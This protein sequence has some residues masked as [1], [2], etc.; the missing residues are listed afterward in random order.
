MS[1]CPHPEPVAGHCTSELEVPRLIPRF[2]SLA[3][4]Y[5]AD[6]VETQ[7][8][9]FAQIEEGLFATFPERR[10]ESPLFFST[11]GR[12]ELCG[13]HTDHNGGMV[14]AASVNLDMVAAA[15]PSAGSLVRIHSEGFGGFELDIGEL[16]PKPDE[17]AS[18][19]ALVR[20]MAEGLSK[21][22]CR[23]SAALSGFDAYIDSRVPPGSGL[24]SS[25]AFEVLVGSIMAIFSGIEISPA[26]LAAIGRDAENRHFGK[27]SGLM[28]QTACALGSLA[29]IDFAN[30]KKAAIRLLS[31][32]PCKFGYSL[33]IVNTQ[34][35]H[36][37]L[38]EDYASIPREMKAVA[39]FLGRK[40]LCGTT[41]RELLSKAVELRAAC[42]DR[43]FLR[44]WHFA[45]ETLRPQALVEAIEAKDIE[46]YL[47]IVRASGDSSYKY[48]Q[49]IHP[50]LGSV[51]NPQPSTAAPNSIATP[52]VAAV[53]S[54][55]AT[56][57]GAAGQS[58]AFALA[59][60]ED[61][62]VGEGA[63]RVHGGGFA[64]T[65]Q[66]YIPT[67]RMGEYT[68]LVEKN[69]GSHSLHWIKL[70]RHGAVCI[71]NS[72]RSSP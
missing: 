20:G 47:T 22:A 38:T 51:R 45:G 39:A 59:L 16:L 46:A 61:F 29:L 7:A 52:S 35:S 32:D 44:A 65:I 34:D 37:D 17:K 5:D 15:L 43:A 70:R 10:I 24:S 62:L 13:N 2:K 33:A 57:S 8:L 18:S 11:P 1:G 9:R 63:C 60:T 26:E 55:D 58:L 69:F 25:A 66:A 14:L 72:S 49:N 27:P 41:R 64:G 28:D 50:S 53:P 40:I 31:F 23:G 48:L 42:G 68:T 30:P 12:T 6:E 21:L 56:T 67:A 3:D 36:A 19:Q 54:T 71:E 4:L